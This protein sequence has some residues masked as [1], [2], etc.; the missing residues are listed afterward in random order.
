M[1]GADTAEDWLDTWAGQVN[2]QA[3]RSV[4][5]S[6]R[7]AA[8]TGTA[9]GRDG[10]IRVTVGSAGQI[11]RLELD[12]RV[13]DLSGPRLADEIMSVMRRAQAALSGL[14]ADQVQDTVGADTETGRAVL[15]SFETRFPTVEREEDR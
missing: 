4:E 12:E 7:V 8:L 9:E 15:H 14:V 13:H 1:D 11:E 10:A 5:L 2:A 3:A 6:R